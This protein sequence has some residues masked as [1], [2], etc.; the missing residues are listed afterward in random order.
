MNGHAFIGFPEMRAAPSPAEKL[1]C[2]LHLTREVS[3]HASASSIASL[4]WPERFVGA[5][6][7]KVINPGTDCHATKLKFHGG[8]KP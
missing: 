7:H 5:P 8:R 3:R 4:D 6:P 1:N 2:R